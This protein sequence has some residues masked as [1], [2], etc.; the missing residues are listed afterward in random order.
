MNCTRK[1]F[2]SRSIHNNYIRYGETCTYLTC[3][4]KW[5]WPRLERRVDLPPRWTFLKT[6][7]SFVVIVKEQNN[8]VFCM[9][10]MFY[11]MKANVESGMTTVKCSRVKTADTV[12]QKLKTVT[13]DLFSPFTNSAEQHVMLASSSFDVSSSFLFFAFFLKFH[14]RTARHFGG[15]HCR[16]FRWLTC[17]TFSSCVLK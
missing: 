11:V 1:S 10:F 5:H 15:S 13:L 16:D 17:K 2:S 7:K 3:P 4:N 14:S 12:L 9:V 8:N 6:Q